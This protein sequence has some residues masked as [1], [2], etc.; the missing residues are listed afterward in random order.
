VN[1]FPGVG[2]A[3]I[4]LAL[5]FWAKRNSAETPVAAMVKRSLISIVRLKLRANRGRHEHRPGW[6]ED[7]A[8]R[9]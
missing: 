6:I 8:R 2:Y 5:F 1:L 9:S 7:A 4:G 3:V